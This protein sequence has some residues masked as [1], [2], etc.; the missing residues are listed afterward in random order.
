MVLYRMVFGY[1]ILHSH[2]RAISRIPPQLGAFAHL[3]EQSSWVLGRH[4]DVY[5]RIIWNVR[6]RE[7]IRRRY[8]AIRVCHAIVIGSVEFYNYDWELAARSPFSIHIQ[9]VNILPFWLTEYWWMLDDTWK[10]I[11]GL[12]NVT[13]LAD[14]CYEKPR[15]LRDLWGLRIARHFKSLNCSCFHIS[16]SKRSTC[17]P[18]K[19]SVIL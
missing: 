3:G 6:F 4:G 14:R 9:G 17:M 12:Q 5:V 7:M 15:T 18:Y 16:C 1:K 19:Y 11:R 10:E 13:Q 8:M 2:R